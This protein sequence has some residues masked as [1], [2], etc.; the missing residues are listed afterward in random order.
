RLHYHPAQGWG[1][2]PPVVASLTTG[3]DMYFDSSHD[4]NKPFKFVMGKQEVICSW[5]EGVAQMSVGQR[6]KMIISPDYAYGPTGHLGIISPNAI[7]IFNVELMK[8]E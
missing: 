7:L 3:T 1:G 2:L 8:L 4:R 5:E 6:A